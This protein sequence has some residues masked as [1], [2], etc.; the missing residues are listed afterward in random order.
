MVDAEWIKDSLGIDSVDETY[1]LVLSVLLPIYVQ[2]VTGNI[3]LTKLTSVQ[4]EEINGVIS[5][6]VG[7]QLGL[8]FA[9]F[10]QNL[11]KF[12]L[13]NVEKDFDIEKT[14]FCSLYETM[15]LAVKSEYGENAS[16]SVKRSGL[17][18]EYS[19]PY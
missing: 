15:L 4:I 13:G 3:D 18:S 16:G 8:T 2:Q 6:G 14:T 19:K 7:C 10:K 12:I 5:L 11:K 17:T 9:N 1:D